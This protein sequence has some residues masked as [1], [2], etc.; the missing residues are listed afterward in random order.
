MNKVFIDDIRTPPSNDWIVV[1]SSKEAID[2]V[3]ANGMP[4]IISFDHDL[5]G[6]DTSMVFLKQ[7][8]EIAFEKGYN[9]PKYFIH[10]ANPIGSKNIQSFMESWKKSQTL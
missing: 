5:G 10:S 3:N 4:D 7:L 1:R 9:P 6:D 2:W 8:F